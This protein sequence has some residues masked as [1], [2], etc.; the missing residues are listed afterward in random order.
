MF[1]EDGNWCVAALIPSHRLGPAS[2]ASEGLGRKSSS[3]APCAPRGGRVGRVS[4]GP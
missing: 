2:S 1:P 3:L 4:G